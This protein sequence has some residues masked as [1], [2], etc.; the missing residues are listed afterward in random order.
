M[1]TLLSA[2]LIAITSSLFAQDRPKLVV[3]IVVDQMRQDYLQR[4]YENFGEGGFKRLMNDGFVARNNHYNYIPTYTAPGHASIYTGTTPRYHGIISNDWYS[5]VLGRSVY[6]V[7][8]TLSKN[9]GG[10]EDSG[11]ISPRNLQ[12]NTITDELKLSTNFRSKVVGI[13]IKDRGAVLPAGH[14]PDGA[15]WFDSRT[16]EFMTSDFYKSELPKWVANFNKQKT[17]DLYLNQ[18][19]TTSLPL[20]HYTQST[21]DNSPY[22][23]GFEGKDTPTFPYDLKELRLKNGPYGLIRT[24]PF[25]NSIVFDMAKAAIKGESMGT[26]EIL[27]FLAV[28]LSSTD[29]IGHNFGP[30]S[31]EIQDTYIKLDQDLKSFLDHL[32]ETVGK[33]NYVIF[34]TA[35]HGVV[36]NPQFLMDH[37]LPAGYTDKNQVKSLFAEVTK[38]QFNNTEYILDVSNDQIFLDRKLIA[39][40]GKDLEEIQKIYAQTAMQVDEI[41]EAFTATDMSRFDYTDPMRQ[42]LQNGYNRKLSGDV[43]VL[44]KA[45]HLSDGYDRKGTTHGSPY[46]YD[47]HVPLLFYGTGVKKGSTTNKTYITDIVPTMSMLLDISLPNGAVTGSPIEDLFE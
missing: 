29:Y 26:D 13:S 28:S 37:N 20:E 1:R 10:S 11:F 41:N 42:S 24:T 6:C 14:T 43:L 47:T 22:E 2:L 44:K 46:T 30:N 8:D 35:D 21:V 31:V 25:G 19:W 45:A 12:V 7:G 23:H 4:F 15:Y 3:G 32:D 9:V 36:S 18:K 39:A 5:R 16:G 40:D 33:G 17:V 34:L 27:D 38:E